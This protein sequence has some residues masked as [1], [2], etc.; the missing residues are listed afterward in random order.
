MGSRIV[1]LAPTFATLGREPRSIVRR[2]RSA[3]YS[4]AF[5]E[6]VREI[7]PASRRDKEA[8]AFTA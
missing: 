7:A 1:P 2:L 8:S 3:P 5:A 6:R 4:V